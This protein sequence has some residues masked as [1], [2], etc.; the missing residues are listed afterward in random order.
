MEIADAGQ[1]IALFLPGEMADDPADAV[2]RLESLEPIRLG[3]AA[4]GALPLAAGEPELVDER[5]GHWSPLFLA[6]GE[7]SPVRGRQDALSQFAG[8]RLGAL[9][10]GRRGPRCASAPAGR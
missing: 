6:V 8:A 4:Q 10:R 2:H 7:D 3:D 1:P 5:I 9:S